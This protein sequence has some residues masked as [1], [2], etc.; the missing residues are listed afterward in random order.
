M[1]G[2][3]A[4]TIIESISRISANIDTEIKDMN[5]PFSCFK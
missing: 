4:N 1:K 2:D 5:D 3:S